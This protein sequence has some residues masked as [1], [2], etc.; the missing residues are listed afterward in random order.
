M[1]T[2]YTPVRQDVGEMDGG[3]PP[4]ALTGFVCTEGDDHVVT[5]SA[6]FPLVML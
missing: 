3:G 6:G 2:L 4:V 1:K 5:P